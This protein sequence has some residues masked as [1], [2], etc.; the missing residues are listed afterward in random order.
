MKAT[1]VFAAMMAAASLGAAQID[2]VIVRQQWPWSTDVKIEYKISGVTSPVNVGVKVY[3]G[4]EELVSENL[5]KSLTGDI[6]GI[7]KDGVGT[8]VIDPVKAFG[9]ARKVLANFKVELVLSDSAANINEVLYKV[10]NLENGECQDVTR[11]QLLNGEMGTIETD[12]SKFTGYNT[13]VSDVIIWT[14]VTNDVKYATTHIVLR[15]IPAKGQT[16]T[17]G[18]P[19]SEIGRKDTDV[20]TK[21]NDTVYGRETQHDVTLTKDFYI[22]VFE[23][24]QY[25]YWKVTGLWPSRYSLETCRNTRPVEQVSYD[26]IR[27]ASGAGTTWP[28]NDTHEVLA[29]SFLGKLRASLSSCGSPKIDIP[30]EAQWEYAC[31]AKTATGWYNGFSPADTYYYNAPANLKAIA[32]FNMNGGYYN[33]VDHKIADTEEAKTLDTNIGTARVGTYKPNAWGLYDMLGNVQEWCLDWYDMF[34]EDEVTDPKGPEKD[35]AFISQYGYPQRVQRG[36]SYC[37][38]HH[39]LRA[40]YRTRDTWTG[41]S[42]PYMNGFRLCLTIEE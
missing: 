11:A 7:S 29:T 42:A 3:D 20:S 14:E 23:V 17:M 12:Y 2:E 21:N 15:K 9:T 10:Y 18:S 31:R 13:P 19:E 40:A 41:T 38:A 25:Q 33:I 34:K 5:P 39:E 8:I 26:N 22:G 6:Y 1:T 28:T 4:E 16:F 35:V 24:T 30:T 32:R 36:G 37:M 27:G